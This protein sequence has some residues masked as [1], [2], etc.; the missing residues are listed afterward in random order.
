M[1][2]SDSTGRSDARAPRL[3]QRW[4][5]LARVDPADRRNASMLQ[6]VLVASA[7][8]QPVSLALAWASAVGVDAMAVGMSIVNMAMLLASLALLRHGAFVAAARLFV[9]V[10]L[11]LLTAA[12]FHWGLA[13]QAPQQ[14]LQLVPVLIGG[15][16][17]GRRAMWTTVA[18]LVALVVVGGW[19]DAAVLAHRPD[20]LLVLGSRMLGSIFG[21][22]MAAFVLDQALAGLRE[23]LALARRRGNELAAARDR[24]QLEMQEKERQRDQLVHA[25]KMEGVGRLASGVA[26]DFNH[27]L[28][29]VL[30]HAARGRASTTL[31]DA[32]G[33]LLDV[34][35]AAR[36]AAAVSRRLL[37]FSRMED[38]RPEVFDPAAAIEEMRPMLRQLFSAGTRLELQLQPSPGLVRFDR[39]QFE[40]ILLTLAANAG[41]AM[42][43]GGRFQVALTAAGPDMIGISARDDGH[44]MDADVRERC[45]EPFFTTKPSGQGTGLGLAVAAG[46]VQA[47]GGSIAIDSAPGHGTNVRIALPRAGSI[48]AERGVPTA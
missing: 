37:D 16:L 2:D 14:L 18:W 20:S 43:V 45:L 7:L 33:A 5:A 30:G 28:T 35:S 1:H 26:H 47:A 22:V 29:L 6:A 32:H 15:A 21:F 11:A 27:L 9:A 19:R 31:D 23:N 42:P 3:L 38:A 8:F 12:Y 39:A 44:G 46:L 25:Q 36:R 40:L 41:D 17:L 10:T 34:Q 48:D 4:R 24:L 13:P